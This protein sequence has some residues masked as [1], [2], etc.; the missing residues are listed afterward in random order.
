MKHSV[1]LV[2]DDASLLQGLRRALHGE[3]YEIVTAGSARAALDVIASQPIDVVVSDEEMPGMRGNQLLASVHA[4]HPDTMRIMMTGQ[5]SLEVA[6]RAINE[7]HAY[8][9]FTKP[10]NVVELAVGIRQALVQR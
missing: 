1:L 9:F 6:M 4:S 7:G 2:D 8:R 10:C 5:A 3:P